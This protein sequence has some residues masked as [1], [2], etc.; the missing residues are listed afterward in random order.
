V[1]WRL[2]AVCAQTDPEAFFPEKGG[3]PAAAKAV[4]AGCPVTGECL[5]WALANDVR[6]GVWG[7]LSAP[8]RGG[9]RRWRGSAS[10][11]GGVR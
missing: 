1:E 4:C 10:T 2:S 9:I 11:V 6:Y 5:E 3:S 7:G 8:Q